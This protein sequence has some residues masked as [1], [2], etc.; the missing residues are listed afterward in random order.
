MPDLTYKCIK[1]NFGGG[2]HWNPTCGAYLGVT[3][4]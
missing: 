2:L 4:R 3:T 1:F